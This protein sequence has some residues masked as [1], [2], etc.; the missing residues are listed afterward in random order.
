M[1]YTKQEKLFIELTR[2]NIDH[3][4]STYNGNLAVEYY[5]DNGNV[6]RITEEGKT[7]MD[8]LTVEAAFYAVAGIVRFHQV[9]GV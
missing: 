9:K 1:N 2:S 7:V 5:I 4:N 3:F 8:L 6:A